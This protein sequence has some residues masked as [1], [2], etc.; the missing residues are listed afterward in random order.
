MHLCQQLDSC[1][2]VQRGVNLPENIHIKTVAN[3]CSKKNVNSLYFE[4]TRHYT[5]FTPKTLINAHILRRSLHLTFPL[6]IRL[7]H[8]TF[9]LAYLFLKT[10]N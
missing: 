1:S 8:E 6:I 5:L 3:P 7:I 2:A 10:T 4:I 9:T